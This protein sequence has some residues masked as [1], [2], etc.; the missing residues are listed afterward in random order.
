MINSH[1][2]QA[3][4]EQVQNPHDRKQSKV[5]IIHPEKMIP[6]KTAYIIIKDG[7]FFVPFNGVTY[8]GDSF[9]IEPIY[10]APLR[11]KETVPLVEKVLNESK[12]MLSWDK[13]EQLLK[14]KDTDQDALLRATKSKSLK[15]LEKTAVF[16]SIQSIKDNTAWVLFLHNP[17]SKKE[18]DPDLMLEF[19]IETP[20]EKLVKIILED[21]KKYN[22][23]K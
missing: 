19:P 1:F 7:I 10:S 12:K 13:A 11:L 16:Y 21:V 18:L 9:L 2:A 23:A 3:L 6:T 5:S 15:N 8:E 22:S 4:K 14:A 17:K 20:I